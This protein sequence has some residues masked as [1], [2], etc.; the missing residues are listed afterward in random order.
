MAAAATIAVPC[1]SS[2]KTGI[3]RR[4]RRRRS[5]S[6]HSGALMSSRLMPPKVGSR[7]AMMSTS[8]SVSVSFTS[9]SNTSIAGE[10]LEQAALALHDRLG[11]ERADVAEAEHRR[12]VRDHGHEV[13]AAGVESGGGRIGMDG[14]AGGSDARGVGE[15]Q[16]ALVGHA[17]DRQDGNLSRAG[18]PMVLERAPIESLDRAVIQVRGARIHLLAHGVTPV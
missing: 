2:W 18:K 3:F 12:A 9:M 4:S 13:G 14:H 10:L 16:I 8:L 11:G 5:I 17:L 7:D 15:S 1:W 6:K